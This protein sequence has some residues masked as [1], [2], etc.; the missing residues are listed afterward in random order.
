MTGF[1]ANFPVHPIISPSGEISVLR[2][3]F[4]SSK[5]NSD[6]WVAIASGW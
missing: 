1:I 2:H 6:F 4:D 5:Y 3:S